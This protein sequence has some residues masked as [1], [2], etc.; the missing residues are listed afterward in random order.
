MKTTIIRHLLLAGAASLIA[1]S[2]RSQINSTEQITYAA[3]STDA[4]N[5]AYPKVDLS[6]LKN[7]VNDEKANRKIARYFIRHFE[8]A[9]SITWGKV[10]NNVSAEFASGDIKTRALF[11][12]KGN[13]IYTINY[14]DEK[15][16][17][18]YYR[19]MLDNLYDC[20]KISQVARVTEALR[21]I[22]VV[23]LETPDK[24]LTVRIENDQPEEVEKFQKPS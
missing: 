21:E 13:L 11:D 23:E 9:E 5:M 3:G 6:A 12:K 20:Y 14:S 22:W 17:S 16:L 4:V 7:Y 8:N 1:F 18:P 15:L 19:T 10:N 2:S 24:F